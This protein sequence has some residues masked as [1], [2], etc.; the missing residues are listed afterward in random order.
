VREG[1][2]SRHAGIGMGAVPAGPLAMAAVAALLLASG[3]LAP[4]LRAP[5]AAP[6]APAERSALAEARAAGHRVEVAAER[7]E[8]AT[9]YANAD[10]TMTMEQRE[11]PIRVRHG[12]GWVPVDPTLR[13]GAGGALTPA[14][15][16]V[17]LHFS[18]GGGSV[19][20]ATLSE[21]AWSLSLA[22]PGPL[23]AP[24]ASGDTATYRDVL[25][26]VDLT[27]RA[28]VEGFTERLVVRTRA[29]AA[30]P[31]LAEIRFDL[32]TT[33]VA[34]RPD[35]GGGLTGTDSSGAQAV[36]VP[37]PAMWDAAAARQAPVGMSLEGGQL[38][39]H[40]DLSMLR[41][42]TTRFPVTI[43]PS[44]NANRLNWTVVL[45]QSP[46][47]SFWNGQNLSSDSHGNGMVGDD[48][49]FLTPARSLFQMNTSAIN[50]KHILG[51]TFQIPEGWASS[52][53]ARE[54]DLWETGGISS[55]T[56]WNSQPSWNYKA[57]SA[58]V[59]YGWSSS[60]P[61][62]TVEFNA[63]QP[64]KDAS[65]SKWP[66]LTL[67]LRA[68]NEGD[69]IAWKRF[70]TNPSLAIDYNSIPNAP[71]ALSA[72]TKG[73]ATGSGRP[74][75]GTATPTLTATVTDPDSDLLN[76]T[77]SWGPVGGSVTG[78]I[79]QNSVASGSQAIVT[80]PAGQMST[81]NSYFFHVQATDTIDSSPVSATCELTVLT[82][83]PAA[84][85]AVTSTDYPNDQSFH[86]GVGQTGSFTLGAN[87]V[88]D[89]V[90]YQYGWQDPP[91]TQVAAPSQGAAATITATPAAEGL[92]TLFV[93][94]VDPAGNLSTIAQYQFLAGGPTGPAGQWLMDEGGGTTLNDSSGSGNTATLS[95][96]TSWTSG[97]TGGT[98][99]A[100]ALDGST[101]FAQTAGP[102]LHTSQSFSVAAWVR[103]ATTSTG[104]WVTAVSQNGSATSSFVLSYDG[105]S[106]AF[107]VNSADSNSPT[108]YR[109]AASA[110]VV[111]GRWTH[112]VGVYDAGPQQLQIYVNGV[113]AGTLANVSPYDSRSTLDIG[114]ALWASG[115]RDWFPGDVD[116]V[117]VW[118][119]VL[120]PSDIQAL[121][122]PTTLVGQWGFDEGSGATTADLSGYGHNLTGTGGYTWTSG[123]TDPGAIT[124]DGSTG[125]FTASG[126]VVLTDQSFT[127]AAWVRLTDASTFRT[128]VAQ[129]GATASAFYLQYDQSD[130]R[131]SFS[132]VSADQSSPVSTRALSTGPPQVG[133]WTFLTGVYDAGAG[134]IRV[135][136][137]GQ[138]QG[139]ASAVAWNA[140]GPLSVGDAKYNGN[141]TDRWAGDVDNV[142]VF[143]GALSDAQVVSLFNS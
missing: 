17:G 46:G 1:V 103:L 135:Y 43:D 20:A 49:T 74:F 110:P 67:G 120:Y 13:T 2:L 7:T 105:S 22:W 44:F 131:W 28:A 139:T 113:L 12:A 126:P 111:A 4:G 102:V 99:H 97:R 125:A 38:V 141:Q 76:T 142:S 114:R 15:T 45:G 93:R 70:Q 37:A 23:P 119:R 129:Q 75:L 81:G 107:A 80:V 50:G 118:N 52:C 62:K 59:A 5:A 30:D 69:T 33:G 68:A 116:D 53:S 35:G 9:V 127:V 66:N 122:N 10:G 137:N 34:L 79:T 51:A 104:R 83:P 47:V 27:L 8:T 121:A 101:G 11:Q 88:S 89:I 128:A 85:P 19:P 90:A 56:T 130:N 96:G 95:G 86:G 58:N 57:A 98:D 26:G 36:A 25:P 124:F 16:S 54:V 109:L 60:C 94:S 123:P 117:Q 132:V 138:L 115:W 71:T 48:P 87:G 73:C 100:V 31:R 84:P 78:S 39:L 6:A 82:T 29:A 42:A 55:G 24:A 140:T 106:W 143:L 92:N 41:A 3:V 21:A 133:T 112:L 72:G 108:P 32:T 14:A 91:V 136:V 134:V 77:F 40:P 61:S 18:G 64:V 63:T 65:N